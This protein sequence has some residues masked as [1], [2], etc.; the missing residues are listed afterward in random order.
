MKCD[1]VDSYPWNPWN[2]FLLLEFDESIWRLEIDLCRLRHAHIRRY[3]LPFL[4][5]KRF[6]K[7][8]SLIYLHLNRVGVVN[9]QFLTLLFQ[10]VGFALIFL[11]HLFLE[12]PEGNIVIYLY[13]PPSILSKKLHILLMLEFIMFFYLL[14][15]GCVTSFEMFS[16]II[17]LFF[18][19]S[20]P[21]LGLFSNYIFL[22]LT[23]EICLWRKVWNHWLIIIIHHTNR[24]RDW[25]NPNCPM[26]IWFPMME[27]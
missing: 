7:L 3:G 20:F 16:F 13:K 1:A 26:A 25:F 22:M 12:F 23:V 19:P 14:D 11:M 10:A 27:I 21:S 17:A 18:W 15:C 24:L 5:F 6:D 4:R 2:I 9:V 8:A